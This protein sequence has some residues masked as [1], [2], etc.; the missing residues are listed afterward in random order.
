VSDESAQLTIITGTGTASTGLPGI[1]STPRIAQPIIT[2]GTNT[3]I[4]GMHDPEI[5][6]KKSPWFSRGWT[7]QE[8]LCSR[9]RLIFTSEQ[10]VFECNEMVTYESQ[11]F[12]PE[13]SQIYPQKLHLPSSAIHGVFKGGFNTLRQ[14]L[15]TH[16]EIY[17]QRNLTYQSDALR[18]FQGICNIFANQKVPILNHWGIPTYLGCYRADGLWLVP[19][20]SLGSR[21]AP[22]NDLSALRYGLLWHLKSRGQGA[23]RRVGFPSWSWAG[24]SAPVE[25]KRLVIFPHDKRLPD[26]KNAHFMEKCLDP[27]EDCNSTGPADSDT[28]TLLASHNSQILAIETDVIELKVRRDFEAVAQ[29]EGEKSASWAIELTTAITRDTVWKSIPNESVDCLLLDHDKSDYGLVVWGNGDV[30]ERLGLI[31]LFSYNPDGTD[32]KLSDYFPTS[33]REVLIC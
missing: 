17:T 30:K 2:I 8:G 22:A 20:A 26:A 33:R 7:Y 16:I 6:I 4:S 18:A 11:K 5:E 27:S 12:D 21:D 29:V 24:W 14:S 9:R 31:K 25:W 19:S 3:W 28:H 23:D 15:V 13:C 32:Y 1:G 10:V